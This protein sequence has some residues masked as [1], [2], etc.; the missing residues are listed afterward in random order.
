MGYPVD[1]FPAEWHRI[2]RQH[3]MLLG[4]LDQEY[5]KSRPGCSEEEFRQRIFNELRILM[6]S[7][8]LE[9]DIDKKKLCEFIEARE[10][11]VI[12]S[13]IAWIYF[14]CAYA[15]ASE[16]AITSGDM[17]LGWQLQCQAHLHYG[18]A[19]STDRSE[20]IF[21]KVVVGEYRKAFSG[22][23]GEVKNELLEKYRNR[24]IEILR[25]KNWI[26]FG[27]AESDIASALEKEFPK[28]KDEN[29]KDI[30]AY[31]PSTIA[32]WLK[33]VPEQELDELIPSY[34]AARERSKA[35]AAKKKT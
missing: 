14:S 32:A 29:G 3:Q 17:D 13:D 27:K 9:D 25:S 19:A 24:A 16:L 10:N 31:K 11:G 12:D 2:L 21:T 35:A 20:E 7:I 18:L 8:L 15:L 26:S 23:G 33:T 22:R 5:C 28:K 34:K 4:G 1:S 6:P 30:E